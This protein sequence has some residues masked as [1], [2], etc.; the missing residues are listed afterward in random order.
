MVDLYTE[1][2]L[3]GADRCHGA[4][5]KHRC[6]DLVVGAV[7]ELY[8]R[9]AGDGEL[10]DRV[11]LRVEA[12]EHNG[13]GARRL[14]GGFGVDAE[15]EEGCARTERHAGVLSE[16]PRAVEAVVRPADGAVECLV[17][18]EDEDRRHGGDRD[19]EEEQEQQEEAER[20]E[21]PPLLDGSPAG[22]AAW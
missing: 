1:I 15:D 4:A 20:A 6:V 9:I 18:G 21:A 22:G 2:A 14:A 11:G 16:A 7:F 10:V 12:H 17:P 8:A 13:V 5:P 3:D 19:D